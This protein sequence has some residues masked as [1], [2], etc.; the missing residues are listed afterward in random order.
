MI[1][2]EAQTIFSA[3]NGHVEVREGRLLP[4]ID[5]EQTFRRIDDAHQPVL[6]QGIRLGDF[7][8]MMCLA[9]RDNTFS[10]PY[11]ITAYDPEVSTMTPAD[12]VSQDPGRYARP[13]LAHQLQLLSPEEIAEFGVESLMKEINLRYPFRQG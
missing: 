3:E 4:L 9:D 2:F 1:L 5:E 7:A 13:D 6:V 12:I 11:L 10:V 8:V